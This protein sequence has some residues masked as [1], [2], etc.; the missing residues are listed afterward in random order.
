MTGK[1]TMNM[2]EGGPAAH[3]TTDINGRWLGADCGSVKPKSD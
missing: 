1:M 2:N 3:M